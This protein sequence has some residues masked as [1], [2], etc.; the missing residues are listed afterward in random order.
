MFDFLSAVVFTLDRLAMV[1]A[2][3]APPNRQ[4]DQFFAQSHM[5]HG[6]MTCGAL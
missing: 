6:R 1:R 5:S 4:H 3:T 2:R